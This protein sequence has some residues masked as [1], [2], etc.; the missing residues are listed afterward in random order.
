MVEGSVDMSEVIN[1]EQESLVR[2]AENARELCRSKPTMML[3]FVCVRTLVK[4]M[5]E[6]NANR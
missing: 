4:Y 6:L 2:E 5:C 1:F 3:L